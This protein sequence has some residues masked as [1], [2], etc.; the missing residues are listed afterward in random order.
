MGNAGFHYVFERAFFAAHHVACPIAVHQHIA[1]T[2][3]PYDFMRIVAGDP[4]R[5]TVPIENPAITIGNVDAFFHLVE[6]QPVEVSIAQ[7]LLNDLSGI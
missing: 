2:Q 4:L 6:Q 5:S 7:S 3:T 1:L